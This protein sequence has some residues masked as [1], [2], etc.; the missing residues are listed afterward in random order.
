VAEGGSESADEHARALAIREL[1]AV[2]APRRHRRPASTLQTIPNSASDEAHPNGRERKIVEAFVRLS[3]HPFFNDFQLAN[4]RLRSPKR[5]FHTPKTPTTRFFPHM[6]WF[7]I[8]PLAKHDPTSLSSNS[9]KFARGQRRLRWIARSLA[10]QPEALNMP[11]SPSTV[12][13]D[14][15][16]GM[17][18]AFK[19]IRK[20]PKPANWDKVASTSKSPLIRDL[21]ILFG[22][23]RALD[24]VKKIALDDKADILARESA[25]KTLIEARRRI[26]ARF[27]RSSLRFALSTSTAVRGLALFDDPEI[28]QKLAPATA[29]SP[30]GIVPPSSTRW[31]RVPPLQKR[32]SKKWPPGKFHAPTSAPFTRGRSAPSMTRRSRKQLTEAWGELRESAADKKQLIEK[33]KAQLT[34][35]TRSPKRT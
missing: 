13:D 12:S 8:S 31:S 27:A 7:G 10:T 35:E 17:T 23:G 32:C 28:G 18:E 11:F 6:V 33:V 22:D 19:G 16:E 26:C 3:S 15:L 20:A 4:G 24:D 14:V 30:Q 34:P 25:L 29:S 9:P 5:C 1:S 2:L 21:S